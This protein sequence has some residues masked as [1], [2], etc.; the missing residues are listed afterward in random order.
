VQGRPTYH[1]GALRQALIDAALS[2]IERCGIDGL[3]LRGLAEQLGVARSAPYRHFDSKN[4]LVLTLVKLVQDE[5]HDAYCAV[6]PD[7]DPLSRVRRASLAYLAYARR[8][9]KL[10]RLLHLDDSYWQKEGIARPT[11]TK[12]SLA[13][14][15]QMLS[16]VMVASDEEALTAATLSCWSALHGYAQICTEK[17]FMNLAEAKFSDDD[18]VD[19]MLMMVA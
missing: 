14:Y 4:A 5:I 7:P 6:L 12:S 10:F 15:R 16:E 2:E 1:H 18:F 17:R 19:R 9:P 3:S 11:P 8:R 13:V